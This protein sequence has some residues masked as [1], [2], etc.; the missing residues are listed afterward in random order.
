MLSACT[1]IEKHTTTQV[2]ALSRSRSGLQ[3]TREEQGS[4]RAVKQRLVE[5][6]CS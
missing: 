3:R 2:V 4:E 5:V 1:R 6:H